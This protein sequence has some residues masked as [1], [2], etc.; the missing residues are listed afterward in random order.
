MNPTLPSR[1]F[2][3]RTKKAFDKHAEWEARADIRA[4]RDALAAAAAE[5]NRAAAEARKAAMLAARCTCPV[6]DT[7][8]IPL[9]LAERVI[10]A[11]ARLPVSVPVD[12]AVLNALRYIAYGDH[13][14]RYALPSTETKLHH[15]RRVDAAAADPAADVRAAITTKSEPIIPAKPRRKLTAAEAHAEADGAVVE[16]DD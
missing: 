12:D 16:T 7:G 1:G 5:A 6:C 2:K 14:E 4:Q 9:D 10:T 11:L 15:P 8:A 3:D 13:V